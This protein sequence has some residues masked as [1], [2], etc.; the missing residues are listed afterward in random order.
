MKITRVYYYDRTSFDAFEPLKGV[1][2]NIEDGEEFD[3]LLEDEIENKLTNVGYVVLQ[4][5]LD[6]LDSDTWEH[7]VDLIQTALSDNKSELVFAQTNSNTVYVYV[8]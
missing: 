2:N 4:K 5:Q 3:M 6:T 8:K 7:V 1:H